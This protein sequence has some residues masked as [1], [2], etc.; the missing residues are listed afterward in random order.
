MTLVTDK[1]YNIM[2]YRVYLAWTGF[3]L[4]ILVVVETDSTGSC[5]FN[6]H[7]IT[8][9][10]APRRYKS[11][12]VRPMYLIS[13]PMTGNREMLAQLPTST[14]H[15]KYYLYVYYWNFIYGFMLFLSFDSQNIVQ[16]CIEIKQ[17]W[18]FKVT[19][20]SMLSV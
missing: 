18:Q 2:L 1:H 9:M 13:L 3:E 11:F 17:L 12:L 16:L 6:Y 15:K 20:E 8:A 7:T 5:K 19:D 10:M 14:R 4:T